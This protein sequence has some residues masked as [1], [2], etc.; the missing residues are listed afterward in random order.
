MRCEPPGKIKKRTGLLI[1][2]KKHLIAIV[3]AA[4]KNEA[5]VII[6]KCTRYRYSC[7]TIRTSHEL[8]CR[9]SS[10]VENSTALLIEVGNSLLVQVCALKRVIT[11]LGIMFYS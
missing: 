2:N 7:M 8:N 9:V 4:D 1:C 3:Y 10:D 5:I 11:C 6:F